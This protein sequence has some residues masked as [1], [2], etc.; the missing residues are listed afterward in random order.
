MGSRWSE[1]LVVGSPHRL[2]AH[3]PLP[4]TRPLCPRQESSTCHR[5]IRQATTDIQPVGILRESSVPNLGPPEDPRDHQER[6]FD[7]R[8]D[9]RLRAVPSP[10][11]FT[12][13][14]RAMGFGLHEAL[15]PGRVLPNDVALPALR[16]IAPHSRLFS[17]QQLR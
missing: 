15:G 17:M 14:S 13:W 6:R 11:G 7:L 2:I 3:G 10:L 1:N 5:Q 8:P 16:G 9:F 4:D 12:Q